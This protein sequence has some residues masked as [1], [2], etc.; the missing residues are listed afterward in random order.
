[1]FLLFFYIETLILLSRQAHKP[2]LKFLVLFPPAPIRQLNKREKDENRRRQE[3]E[4]LF[5]VGA[6]QERD[7]IRPMGSVPPLSWQE[8]EGSAWE[9]GA[10]RLCSSAMRLWGI[11]G[12]DQLY[13]ARPEAF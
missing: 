1:M 8:G 7:Y 6:E 2:L 13:L 12:S 11:R 10:L 9:W 3:S 5:K 4:E